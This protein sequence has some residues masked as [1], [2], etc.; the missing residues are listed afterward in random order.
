MQNAKKA[1][2][3]PSHV[4]KGDIFDD[5]GLS[6]S[7]AI[8]AKV[9]AELWRDLVHHIKA[10]ALPQRE[11]AKRLGV[12]QADVSNLL[13]GK[14]SKF[15]AGTL[16]HYAVRLNIRVQVKLIAPKALKS[17]LRGEAAKVRKMTGTRH[18]EQAME[19]AA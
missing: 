17:D 9:K 4:T 11:L 18:K 13:N 19:V 3:R 6:P 7:E 10:L 5:L 15:S 16:I 14:L 2:N 12:Y 1:V 8:E